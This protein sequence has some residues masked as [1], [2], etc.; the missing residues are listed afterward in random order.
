LAAVRKEMTVIPF[1]AL[2]Q[3]LINRIGAFASAAPG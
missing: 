1:P 3:E 2:R